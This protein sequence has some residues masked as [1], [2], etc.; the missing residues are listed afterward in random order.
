MEDYPD[1]S[2]GV[3]SER[4]ITLYAVEVESFPTTIGLVD[5][6]DFLGA[7]FAQDIDQG[8]YG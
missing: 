5:S 6:G 1:G 4:M 7:S 3:R 2:T 8:G